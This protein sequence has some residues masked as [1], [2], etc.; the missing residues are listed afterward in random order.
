[1]GPIAAG[2]AFGWVPALL[3]IIIGSIFIGGVHDFT[4]LV[5][6]I[7]HKARSITEVVHENMSRRAYLM[8]LGFIWIALIYII[9]AFTDVTAQS[10]VGEVVPENGDK[11]L[12]AGI[13]SS[14]ILYL[15]LPLVMGLLMK[16]AKLSV[17]WDT[18]IFLP[19]VGVAIWAGQYTPLCLDQWL[20][21]RFSMDPKA[22]AQTALKIW[23]VGLLA[24][25]FVAGIVPMW[26]L[27]QPRGH[28][29][30]C[31]LYAVI[32]SGG[33]GLLFSGKTVN[34]PAFQSWTSASGDS[35]FPFLFITIA[36]GA[37]SGFHAIVASGTSSKQLRSET[38]AKVVG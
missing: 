10:F 13:A 21:D 4:A 38:D 19:L 34:Y 22:A 2:L 17:A 36:C 31:F 28:P 15:V 5:S 27:L 18:V 11:V 32:I 14:S 24:Y 8:F 20:A 37:C 23:D 16:Y 30:G 33:L 7:R 25:C 1:M 35:V 26:L 12:G 29:G 3:W 6:S 9:I